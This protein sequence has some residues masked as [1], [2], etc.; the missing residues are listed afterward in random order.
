MSPP[1]PSD[2][3]RQAGV[4]TIS[5]YCAD[6]LSKKLVLAGRPARTEEELLDASRHVWCRRTMQAV[7][8][9]GGLVHPEDCRMGRG[10]FRSYSGP[11]I[12]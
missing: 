6:L 2:K 8:P 10:C 9:D 1:S 4:A 5:P 3:L 7:G 12:A 11:R